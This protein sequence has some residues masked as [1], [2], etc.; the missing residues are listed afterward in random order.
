MKEVNKELS[1]LFKLS[2]P[3][4]NQADWTQICIDIEATFDWVYFLEKAISSN[5]AGYLLPYPEIAEAYYPTLVINKIKAYQHKIQIHSVQ[6]LDLV[7]LLHANLEKLELKHAFLKGCD[8]LIRGNEKLKQ[9]QVSDIDILI[10]ESDINAFIQVL[11]QL[12]CNVWT[13][14]QKSD[15]HEKNHIQHAPVQATLGNLKI[16]VHFHLFNSTTSYQISTAAL[17]NEVEKHSFQGQQLPL[18][19]WKAA[20]LFCVLHVYKHL[21]YG[22]MFKVA[23]INDL[24][25][26]D[27]EAL[28]ELALIWNARKAF[29]EMDAFWKTWLSKKYEHTFLGRTVLWFMTGRR[30]TLQE[31]FIFTGRRLPAHQKEFWNIQHLYKTIFPDHA[32][33]NQH[34]GGGP[35]LKSWFRRFKKLF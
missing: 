21:Y 15:W 27:F 5:L 29:I 6:L 4:I 18:L 2:N 22:S 23:A 14:V 3:N 28:Q 9:R 30:R 17:L 11:E 33:L 31:K 34:F 16:D 19:P 1:T 7:L 25:R 10:N 8:T 20:Q 35:Y 32:Y 24:Y 12:G 26:I 13:S